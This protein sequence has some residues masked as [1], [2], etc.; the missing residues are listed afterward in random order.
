MQTDVRQMQPHRPP[1]G[2]LIGLVEILA[3]AVEIAG[4]GAVEGAGEEAAGEVMLTA[5]T[6][7]DVDGFLEVI[8]GGRLTA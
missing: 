5:G 1:L 4:D 2:D 8:G 6:A 3:R 7:Q